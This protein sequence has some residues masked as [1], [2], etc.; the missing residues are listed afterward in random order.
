MGKLQPGHRS[1]EAVVKAQRSSSLVPMLEGHLLGLQPA[2]PAASTW[3]GQGLPR[4]WDG[5][6]WGSRDAR[7]FGAA[8][9][10]MG[11]SR[12]VAVPGDTSLTAAWC[13]RGGNGSGGQEPKAPNSVPALEQLFEAKGSWSEHLAGQVESKERLKNNRTHQTSP[14]SPGGHM[15]RRGGCSISM[16]PPKPD[17]S[18]TT[19]PRGGGGEHVRS[20]WAALLSGRASPGMGSAVGW[21]QTP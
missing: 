8:L 3:H 4:G 14:P 2:R 16:L 17:P 5:T 13:Q 6:G 20:G 21:K 11:S 18:R 19:L 12:E 9:G 7:L 1:Y 10:L 15:C